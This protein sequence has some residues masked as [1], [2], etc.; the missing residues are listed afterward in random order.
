MSSLLSFYLSLT[1]STVS[2]VQQLL[3]TMRSRK[4]LVVIS[5][6]SLLVLFVYLLLK[7]PYLSSSPSLSDRAE[8]NTAPPTKG[9]TQEE[10][11][12]LRGG[13]EPGGAEASPLLSFQARLQAKG[14]GGKAVWGRRRGTEGG[15][16]RRRD[17]QEE[18][19]GGEESK[20]LYFTHDDWPQL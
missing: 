8:V 5:L 16:A 7:N 11:R 18:A 19:E 20:G 4:R 15:G 3:A 10:T 12:T 17:S 13:F 14:V 1:R 9:P 6:I 2:F